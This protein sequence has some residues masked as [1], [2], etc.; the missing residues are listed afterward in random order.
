MFL[1]NIDLIP[2]LNG[3]LPYQAIRKHV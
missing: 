1:K 2:F 3:N